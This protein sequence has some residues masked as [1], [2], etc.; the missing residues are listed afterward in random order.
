[1]SHN[2]LLYILFNYKVLLKII[3]NTFKMWKNLEIKVD[4]LFEP[5]DKLPTTLKATIIV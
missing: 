2:K 4:L 1:M 3:D 5:P